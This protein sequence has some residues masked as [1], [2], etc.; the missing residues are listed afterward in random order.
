MDKELI[1]KMI[2]AAV[3]SGQIKL[4]PV[5]ISKSKVPSADA[6]DNAIRNVQQLN[7]LISSVYAAVGDFKR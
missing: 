1:T 3:A 2:L 7:V 5:D 4:A 6:K